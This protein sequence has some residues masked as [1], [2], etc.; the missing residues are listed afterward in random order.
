LPTEPRPASTVAASAFAPAASTAQETLR[1][2]A[3]D[4]RAALTSSDLPIDWAVAKPGLVREFG[5]IG[6]V[7]TLFLFDAGGATAG[8][9]FGAPPTLHAR[10]EADLAIHIGGR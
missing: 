4:L 8:V 1:E 6:A 5:D 9:L 7:P 10:V 2:R 3:Q